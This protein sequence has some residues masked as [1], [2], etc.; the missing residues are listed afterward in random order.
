MAYSYKNFKFWNPTK[1]YKLRKEIILNSLYTRDYSNTFNIPDE[2]CCNFFNGYVEFL[3][4]YMPVNIGVHDNE[5]FT[6]L[7]ELDNKETLWEYF[8]L[9][10]ICPFI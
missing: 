8:M 10:D 1:L 2:K 3:A 4:D 7:H 6:L 5:Y 9:F